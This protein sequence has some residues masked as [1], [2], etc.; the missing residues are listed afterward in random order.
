MYLLQRYPNLAT[1]SDSNES[2][3]LNV[4]SKLPSHFQSGHKLGFWKRCIYHCKYNFFR[5]K[6]FMPRNTNTDPGYDIDSDTY[7]P[8]IYL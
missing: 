5:C 1:I 4:L 3:I 7:A 2:I 8:V 6:T